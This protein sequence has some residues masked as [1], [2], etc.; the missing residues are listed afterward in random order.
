[1]DR[2]DKVAVIDDDDIYQYLLKKELKST[3]IV[4]KTVVFSDGAKAMEFMRNAKDS[5]EK[6]PDVIFL[7]VNMPI[8]NGWE[9]LDEFIKLQ[10]NLSKEIIILIV[11]SSFDQRDIERANKYSEISDYIVKPV[12]RNRLV[13]VLKSL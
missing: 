4:D 3:N 5:P 2:I 1:M 12:T 8:M 11:S 10:P 7:D 9:F 6:L 13:S